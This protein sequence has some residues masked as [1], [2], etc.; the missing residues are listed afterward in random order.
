MLA[1]NEH[2]E[3]TALID[4]VHLRED[5]YPALRLLYAIPN[6]A[7]LPYGKNKQGK[8]FSFQAMR[9][10][11]EGLRP[12]VPD[13]CLPAPRKDFCGLYIELKVGKNKPTAAQKVF[14]DALSEQGYLAVVCWGWDDARRV[15]CE[16]LDIEE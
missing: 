15:L 8:R 1:T 3:Q 16:Y 13:L 12:G 2:T 6:G 9:L 11:A 10:L 5:R 4:W 7:K 14:L